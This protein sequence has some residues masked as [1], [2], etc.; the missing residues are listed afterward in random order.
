[1][2]ISFSVFALFAVL[3]KI[4]QMLYFNHMFM[5][6]THENIEDLSEKIHLKDMFIDVIKKKRR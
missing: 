5:V 2:V 6:S 1:M 4:L 3:S